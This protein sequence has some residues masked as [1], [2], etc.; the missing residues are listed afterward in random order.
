M[1]SNAD[2]SCRHMPAC[3]LVLPRIVPSSRIFRPTGTRSLSMAEYLG[4]LPGFQLLVVWNRP[5]AR[6]CCLS[7]LLYAHA[8]LPVSRI[9]TLDDGNYGDLSAERQWGSGKNKNKQN[10]IACKSWWA[11]FG[12]PTVFPWVPRDFCPSSKYFSHYTSEGLLYSF[13]VYQS[14]AGNV[15]TQALQRFIIEV[16]RNDLC[17][18][19]TPESEACLQHWTIPS[20]HIMY[21]LQFFYF[22]LLVHIIFLDGPVVVVMWWWCGDSM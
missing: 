10:K 8:V 2:L 15:I 18:K 3:N 19:L 6:K 4:S 21:H 14:K 11:F 20:A 22:A 1:G 16:A 9:I 17:E 7:T 5:L 12:C 13:C